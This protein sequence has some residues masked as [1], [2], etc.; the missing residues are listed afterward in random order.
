MLDELPHL[1]DSSYGARFI[2]PLD[3]HPPDWRERRAQLN[4]QP[5]ADVQ[6]AF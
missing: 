5:L 1:I 2:E 3:A 4:A 6:T